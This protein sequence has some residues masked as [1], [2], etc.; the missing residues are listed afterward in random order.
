M[1]TLNEG[2][3]TRGTLLVRFGSDSGPEG[4]H[5]DGDVARKRSAPSSRTRSGERSRIGKC[6]YGRRCAVAD[7]D[8]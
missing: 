3:A 5:I 2:E 4:P 6:D 1:K 7:R 8:R